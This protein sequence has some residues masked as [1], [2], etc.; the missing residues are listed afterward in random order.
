MYVEDLLNTDESDD[1]DRFDKSSG[2]K[3]NKKVF[4]NKPYD[5]KN[6]GLLAF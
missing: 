1:T 2:E 3:K 5:E 6:N 4:D